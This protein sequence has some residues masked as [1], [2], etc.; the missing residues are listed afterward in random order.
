M[1]RSTSFG[2]SSSRR[3]ASTCATESRSSSPTGCASALPPLHLSSYEEYYRLLV[4]G[5]A[6]EEEL[7]NFID[8]VS[9]NETY[10][11]REINH[12]TV[13]RKTVLP[14]LIKRKH[15]ARIWSAGC[16]TGEEVYTLRIVVNEALA[17]CGQPGAEARSSAPT[18]AP[19]PSHR[20]GT[21]STS[22]APCGSCRRRLLDRYFAPA[23]AGAR[24]VR[25][26]DPRLRG[27]PGAQPVQGPRPR[28]AVS[29]S[30][31]AATS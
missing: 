25:P 11:F 27:V 20:P 28:R 3:P 29:T 21:A 9:T 1:R 15:R 22:S 14:E 7:H 18:S 19:R 24:Q 2:P 12:F 5:S 23:E 4:S 17:E 8:A 10:F 30:S 6:G 31:S 13:L 26:A 16:S